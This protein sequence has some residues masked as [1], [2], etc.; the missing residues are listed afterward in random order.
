[1]EFSF[2]TSELVGYAQISLRDFL[3]ER[4]RPG[5]MPGLNRG[6]R[7]VLDADL[8]E[9]DRPEQPPKW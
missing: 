6:R 8:G 5:G 4:K 7:Y 9:E 2:P 3:C 1:M